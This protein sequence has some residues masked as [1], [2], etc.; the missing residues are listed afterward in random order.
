MKK[1]L[2]ILLALLAA[3]FLTVMISVSVS[4]SSV[5]ESSEVIKF[6]KADKNIEGFHEIKAA[7]KAC[8]GIIHYSG[9]KIV[10]YKDDVSEELAD[11]VRSLWIEGSDIYYDSGSVLYTYSLETGET[12]ETAEKPYNILGKYDGNIISYDGRSIYSIN[13][14]GK[15]KIFKDGYYLNSAVLYKNKVYGIPASNVYEYDLDIL[16][17]NKVTD[18]PEGS[19]LRMTGGELYIVTVEKSMGKR[20]HTYSKMTDEG[21]KKI[22]TVKNADM[23]TGE[24]PVRDGM[25]IET[26][27]SFDDSSDGNMLLYIK[28]GKMIKA[29]EDYSYYTIGIIGSKLCYYKNRYQYGTYDENLTT[30]YLY[31]GK[32]S[33]AAFDIDVGSFETV[34]GYEYDGGLLIEVAYE[35]MT[36]LYKYDGETIEE[37]ETPGSFYSIIGLDI[38]DDKAYIRYSDGE[39]SMQSL[40]TVID[41]H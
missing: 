21:L 15:T 24:K 36:R 9:D 31:D 10:Y 40:G 5:T 37:L 17:V 8:G 2:I 13:E 6:E 28:D 16:K 23:I 1:V 32:E 26:A 25:F 12:K 3:V 19:S 20:N 14:T 11:G 34:E 4:S 39:E 22:F 41:L 7:E 18:D 35:L 27:N 33:K 29:D 30:F 38:I